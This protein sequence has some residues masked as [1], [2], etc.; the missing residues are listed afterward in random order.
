MAT[1]GC[2]QNRDSRASDS[3]ADQAS[4]ASSQASER[5]A[6]T[7]EDPKATESGAGGTEAE[8]DMQDELEAY[9]TKFDDQVDWRFHDQDE[10]RL[11]GEWRCTDGSGCTVIFWPD[12][13]YS[14]DFAGTMTKGR[15]AI[16]RDGRIAA[17]SRSTTAQI[18]SHYWFDGDSLVGPNGPL[19]MVP[20]KKTGPAPN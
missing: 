4:E 6:S 3:K 8:V 13:R 10:G 5:D 17:V 15:Y 11:A 7:A 2:G 9:L 14:E 1:A 20:W 18:N 19:P 12:G 16:S